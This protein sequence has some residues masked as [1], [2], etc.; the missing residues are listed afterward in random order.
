[1]NI[2]ILAGGGAKAASGDQ[3]YPV[4]LSEL[5]GSMAIERQVKAFSLG[6]ARFVFAFRQ[7]DIDNHHV[8]SIAEQI[9]PGCGIVRVSRDTAGAACTALLAVGHIDPDDELIVAGSTDHAD[10]DY[11]AILADFRVRA[12]DAGILTFDSLHP[13]Y[14]F[15]KLDAD[16]WVVEAAEKRPI[17]RC[18][19]AGFYWYRRAGD[20]IDSLKA[21]ILKDAQVNGVFY[22][23]PAMNE[24]VLKGRRIA[25]R[26]LAPE[27]YQP[28]KDQRQVE[29]LEHRLEERARHA[30]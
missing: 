2:L 11:G 17:S 24:L 16:G 20:F 15:V 18:A 13:R 6:D 10:V 26:H 29:V 1:M 14:S 21:M 27:Q 4:W 23:S 22:L 3:T 12:A 28:L 7:A 8:D 30:T 5:D 19:N 25:T 9:A